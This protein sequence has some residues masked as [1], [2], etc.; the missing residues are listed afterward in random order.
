MAFDR[1]DR[2]KLGEMLRK[3]RMREQ[4]K[5]RIMKTYKE[6]KSIIKIGNRKSEELW[7]KSGVR[8]GCHESHA[9]QHLSHGSED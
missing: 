3:I 6:T 7:T 8:Q 1:I 4:L 9:I 5:R 2:V